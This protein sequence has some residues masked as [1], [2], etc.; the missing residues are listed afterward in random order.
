M[1]SWTEAISMALLCSSPK[2]GVYERF[3]EEPDTFPVQ[4]APGLIRR[5]EIAEKL[6]I[7]REGWEELMKLMKQ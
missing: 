7:N 5:K 3:I 2:T 6:D 4:K 1:R